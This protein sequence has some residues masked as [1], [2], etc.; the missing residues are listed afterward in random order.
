SW[1]YASTGKPGE[2]RPHRTVG[3]P[4]GHCLSGRTDYGT[5]EFGTLTFTN[6]HKPFDHI[7]RTSKQEVIKMYEEEILKELK[8]MNERL[9]RLEICLSDAATT[10]VQDSPIA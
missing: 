2:Q 4:D 3:V 7:S 10:G 5:D 6:L 8:I 1:E 9:A